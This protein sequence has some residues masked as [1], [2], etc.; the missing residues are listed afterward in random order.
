MTLPSW[1][2]DTVEVIEPAWVDERGT[3]TPDYDNPTSTT[4]VPGCDVQPG[5][6]GEDLAARQGVTIRHTVYAPPGTAVNALSAVR[7]EGTV[8]AIDGEPMRWKSPTGA[9]SH[10]LIYLIDWKG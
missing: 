9:V 10:V 1:A 3:A 4:P 5:A 7:Y 2:S 8:Y 6:S